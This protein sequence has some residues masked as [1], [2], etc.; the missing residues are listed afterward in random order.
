MARTTEGGTAHGGSRRVCL[1]IPAALGIALLGYLTYAVLG[2]GGVWSESWQQQDVS[3]R[4]LLS[5]PGRM[6]QG[7]AARVGRDVTA[8]V[9]RGASI[10]VPPWSGTEPLGFVLLGIDQR[11]AEPTRSDTIIVLWVDPVRKTGLVLSV[12]RDLYVDIPGYGR[13]RINEAFRI[14]GPDFT[15]QVAAQVLGFDIPYHVVIDLQGFRHIIDTL[16]GVEI[17]VDRAIDD[18]RYPDDDFGYAPVSIPAGRQR[19]NGELALAYA[20]S[21]NDDPEYDF[22]RS[23]RQQRLMLALKRQFLQ[24]STLLRV[25]VLAGQLQD[26]VS[27]NFPLA[28]VPSLARLGL[29]IDESRIV[30]GAITY[31]DGLVSDYVTRAGAMVLAP[32]LARVRALVQDALSRTAALPVPDRE[33]VDEQP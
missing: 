19:L 10:V 18:L 13:D 23:K 14:G 28:S 7:T 20:R 5:L 1:L 16:G 8:T 11:H 3:V 2:P 9:N 17:D 29:Q 25:P 31:Q 12:P 21:R 4:S 32:N 30:T 27:T 26:T 22:G 24:P 33:P 15:R 6:G